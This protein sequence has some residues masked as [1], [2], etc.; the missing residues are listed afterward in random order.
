MLL[1]AMRTVPAEEREP[2]GKT[3][4]RAGCAEGPERALA[5][6]TN[7]ARGYALV[8]GR[9]GVVMDDLPLIVAVTVSSI[10]G[11]ASAIFR[12]AVEKGGKLGAADIRVLLGAEHLETARTRMRFLDAVGVLEFVTRGTGK[13]GFLRFRPEWKWCA[14]DEFRRLLL[15]S[16]DGVREPEPCEVLEAVSPEGVCTKLSASN[17]AEHQKRGRRR[18]KRTVHTGPQK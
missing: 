2:S 1:A 17:L 6:L 15:G 16:P 12:A 5:V 14:S 9:R 4:Y 7:L 13:P 3:V 10:P 18:E 8:H 11:D